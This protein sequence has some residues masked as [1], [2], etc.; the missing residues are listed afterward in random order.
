MIHDQAALGIVSTRLPLKIGMS[1][2]RG[3]ER[4]SAAEAIWMACSMEE[5]SVTV[6]SVSYGWRNLQD[7]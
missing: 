2:N 6:S 5:H 4:Y 3:K 7:S 1:R